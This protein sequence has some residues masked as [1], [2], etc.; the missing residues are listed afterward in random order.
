MQPTF[1]KDHDE[2]L[3]CLK[4]SV[5]IDSGAATAVTNRSAT[6]S[7]RRSGF[8]SLDEDCE[9]RVINKV[10]FPTI[11]LKTTIPYL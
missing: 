8:F 9:H 11:P 5:T 6:H 4:M 10:E 7:A 1:G 3:V 2:F